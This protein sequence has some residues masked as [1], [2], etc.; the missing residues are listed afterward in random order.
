MRTTRIIPLSIYFT[1][2]WWDRYFQPSRPRPA[3]IDLNW[4]DDVYIE[5]QKFLYEQFGEFEIGSAGPVLDCAFMSKLLPVNGVLIPYILGVELKAK[6]QGGFHWSRLSEDKIRKLRP[7]DIA[8]TPAA[9]LILKKKQ[10][11]LDRYGAISYMIEYGSATNNAFLIRGDEF[12]LDLLADQPFAHYYLDVVTETMCLAYTF[13]AKNGMTEKDFV[14]ANCNVHMLSPKLYGEMIRDYDSR[15]VMHFAELNHSNPS[16]MIHHCSVSSDPFVQE[17][18]RMPGVHTIQACYHS[19]IPLI[20]QN[21]PH[22]EFSAMLSPVEFMTGKMTEIVTDAEKVIRHGIKDL[23][24]WNLDPTCS[25]EQFRDFLTGLKRLESVYNV[26]F[27]CEPTVI[28]WE[29][30]DWEFPQYHN[31]FISNGT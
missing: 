30:L 23:N 7:I 4:L 19:D 2:Q 10:A 6:E 16:C 1:W 17:Y 18:V 25:C 22:I 14:L 20:K 21:A 28:T 26:K 3:S 31:E 27:K 9:E 15:C 12:Y 24:L 13:F 11:L 8:Q 5:R 29:E